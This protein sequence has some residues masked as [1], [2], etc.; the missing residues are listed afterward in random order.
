MRELKHAVDLDP[1]RA[2]FHMYVGW[3]AMDGASPD[4]ALANSEVDQALSLDKGLSDAWWLKGLL[5]CRSGGLDTGLR[6]VKRS[7]ELRPTRGEAHAALAECSE[8]RNDAGGA[9]GEWSRAVAS[10]PTNAFWQYRLGKALYEKKSGGEAMKHFAV[11]ST[12]AQTMEPRPAW[13]VPLEFAYAES[14]RKAGNRADA[15]QHYLRYI[16]AAP[17]SSPD[18]RDAQLAIAE[19][20]ARGVH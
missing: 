7:I 4:L 6:D 8:L 11:A 9:I 1:N 12:A 15:L 13:V 14:L 18:Y 2:E 3:L 19:L 17:L 16:A 10:D 20:K 5:E